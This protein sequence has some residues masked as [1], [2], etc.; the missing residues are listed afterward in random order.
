[1]NL[2]TILSDEIEAEHFGFGGRGEEVTFFVAGS[3]GAADW[4]GNGEGMR[5]SGAGEAATASRYDTMPRWAPDA[6][7]QRLY[8]REEIPAGGK[9]LQPLRFATGRFA[10]QRLYGA[11]PK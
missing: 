11:P 5:E 4:V 3:D 2:G 9:T 6:A 10:A 1:M 8:K 7:A